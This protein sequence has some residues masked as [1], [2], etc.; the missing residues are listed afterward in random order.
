MSK[1]YVTIGKNVKVKFVKDRPGHD[2]RY[3]LN[4]DKIKNSLKWRPKTN[5]KEGIKLTFEW[6]LKNNAYYKSFDKKDILRRLGNK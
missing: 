2:A 3:A 4:S 6:Y 5:F 1:K